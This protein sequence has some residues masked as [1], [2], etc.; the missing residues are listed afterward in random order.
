MVEGV[1]VALAQ[2]VAPAAVPRLVTVGVAVVGAVGPGALDDLPGGARA[3]W[4][5]LEAEK[6]SFPMHPR[7]GYGFMERT[8]QGC[9]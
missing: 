2:T 6:Y 3:R 8:G 5:E 7:I 1:L 9:G 4:A